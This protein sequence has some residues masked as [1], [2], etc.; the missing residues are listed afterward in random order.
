MRFT[1][2]SDDGSRIVLRDQR[3]DQKGWYLG[4][5]IKGWFG[6][7]APREDTTESVGRDG[8]FWPT[9]ITQGGRTVT[10]S[11]V[12]RARSTMELARALD[13]IDALV[14]ARLTVICEDAHGRRSAEGFLSD[15]PDPQVYPDERTATFDLIITCPD[16]RLY[17]PWVA[18][19]GTGTAR[20]ANHGT[21]PSFPRVHAEGS[22]LTTLALSCGGQV[23]E[24]KGSAT[25]LDLDLS[26]LVP[27]TGTLS[28]DNAFEVPPGGATVSV[29]ATG[30]D[31]AVT[32]FGRDAWR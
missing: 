20:V 9:T 11:G 2:I 16:P 19:T 12:I 28:Q 10:L 21:A 17:G 14:G 13:R 4:S 6:S 1:I 18:Y 30:T 15:D 32:I 23:V 8:D 27:S 22:T 3:L 7:P 5:T 31:A 29:S 25:E 26:D 24:W